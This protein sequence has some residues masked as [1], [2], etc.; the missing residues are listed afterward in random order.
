MKYLLLILIP[1]FLTAQITGK[2]IR[3]K[4]GDTIV[5]L[6]SLYNQYTIRVADID[7]PE[8][9]QPFS[10]KA[11]QFVSKEIYRKQVFVQVKSKDRYGRTIGYV[12]YDEKNLSEELLKKGLAWHYVRYSDRNDFQGF[13]DQAHFDKIGLWIEPN[14]INPEK[15]R[16]QKRN[17]K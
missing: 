17:K 2:V 10:K 11:K 7:C 16:K 1:T 8:Y 14:P 6:D 13:E 15:W 4:D 3:V 5:I 12:F 9:G